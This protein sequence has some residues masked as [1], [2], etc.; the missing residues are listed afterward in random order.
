MILNEFGLS[1][2]NTVF[3]TCFKLNWFKFIPTVILLPTASDSAQKAYTFIGSWAAPN[4]ETV[5][6]TTCV[7]TALNCVI[8]GVNTSFN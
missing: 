1:P 7:Y 4:R 3:C 6:K 5:C 8:C 2:N